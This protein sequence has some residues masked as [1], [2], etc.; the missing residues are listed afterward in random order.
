MHVCVSVADSLFPRRD[1]PTHTHRARE[2]IGLHLQTI[3]SHLLC[4]SLLS[5]RSCVQIVYTLGDRPRFS[6]QSSGSFAAA[7]SLFLSFLCASVYLSLAATAPSSERPGKNTQERPKVIRRCFAIALPCMRYFVPHRSAVPAVVVFVVL[8][9]VFVCFLSTNEP[10]S[11]S[12]CMR[13][14][15]H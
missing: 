1:R 9:L 10:I 12:L 4:E 7:F 8:K 14:H 3:E 2:E 11:A 13:A 5:V 15:E 6:G